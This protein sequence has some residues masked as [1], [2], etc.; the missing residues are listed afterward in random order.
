M[1]E[2]KLAVEDGRSL[3]LSK[4]PLSV[5]NQIYHYKRHQANLFAF[6]RLLSTHMK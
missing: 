6:H 4:R 1:G 3:Q 2:V 5:G